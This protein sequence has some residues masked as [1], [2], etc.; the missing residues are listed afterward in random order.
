MKVFDGQVRCLDEIRGAVE[1]N[2]GGDASHARRASRRRSGPAGRLLSV[3]LDTM[4]Q[5]EETERRTT[6]DELMLGVLKR[7]GE[8]GRGGE[9]V[10]DAREKAPQSRERD[11]GH[12]GHAREKR[13]AGLA[14]EVAERQGRH[15]ERRRVRRGRL[16]AKPA[17][18][19]SS[20]HFWRSGVHRARVWIRGVVRGGD[21]G[22]SDALRV[23]RRRRDVAA[24]AA[25]DSLVKVRHLR[26]EDH[27]AR[28]RRA[29]EIR[30]GNDPLGIL[31]LDVPRDTVR[32]L[33]RRFASRFRRG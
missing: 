23:S 12:G 2:G 19:Q 14:G 33:R 26:H 13:V 9:L 6:H 8:P 24:T 20:R 4:L 31:R 27:R 15:L 29:G 21:H 32:I 5:R 30:R 7:H 17:P 28:H 3:V 10:V 25:G 22:G 11:V 18:E 16:R 1:R